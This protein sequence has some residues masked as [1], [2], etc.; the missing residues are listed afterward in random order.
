MQPILASSRLNL[1]PHVCTCYGQ[2][3]ATHRLLEYMPPSPPKEALKACRHVQ[4]LPSDNQQRVHAMTTSSGFFFFFFFLV[5]GN[6]AVKLHT[7]ELSDNCLYCFKHLEALATDSAPSQHTLC[8]Q[9]LPITGMCGIWIPSYSLVEHLN[10]FYDS[11]KVDN[12]FTCATFL[13]LS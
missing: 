2:T 9:T 1:N 6:S 8:T 12:L 7:L 11:H 4:K 5:N 13:Q 10:D 3:Y